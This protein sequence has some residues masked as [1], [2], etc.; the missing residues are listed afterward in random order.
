MRHIYEDD[1]EYHLLKQEAAVEKQRYLQ[2]L[3]KSI[4]H[5]SHPDRVDDWDYEDD[6]SNETS[7]LS[8]VS[9]GSSFYS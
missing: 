4:R 5:H 8:G 2:Q 9:N 7:L 1:T 3:K 6:V